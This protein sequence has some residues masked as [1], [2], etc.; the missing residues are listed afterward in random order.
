MVY[1]QALLPAF[2]LIILG[3]LLRQQEWVARPL[4]K[5]IESLTYF[6][7]LPSLLFSS[8]ASANF[9]GV[10][11][12]PLLSGAMSVAIVLMSLL[13][14][15]VRPL[16][17]VDGP[18]FTSIYQG[19]IR[20][21]VYIPITASAT[22]YGEQG[23]VLA[24]LVVAVL[25]PLGNI[26]SVSVLAFFADSQR[27]LNKALRAVVTNPMILACGLG[28]GLNLSGIGLADEL[29]TVFSGLGKAALPLG[30]M[31]VGAGLK[32]NTG[33]IWQQST[34]VA[35]TAFKLLLFPALTLLVCLLLGVAPA[36]TTVAVL[37]AA[38]PGSGSA[39]VLAGQMGGN[40]PLL[41]AMITTQT[42]LAMLTLPLM[43]WLTDA[44]V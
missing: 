23:L 26:L 43:L 18:S 17:K 20:P 15:A 16:C 24:S 8:L 9:Q 36:A 25:V 39:Y 29:E 1:L 6:L 33:D 38:V 7:L 31:A 11:N 32:A 41:A 12:A 5:K 13:L 35:T 28:L 10:S 21:N 4:W 34:V 40:Q 2:A 27:S 44:L 22:L 19:A 42:M 30:L 37:F 3:Y 14:L